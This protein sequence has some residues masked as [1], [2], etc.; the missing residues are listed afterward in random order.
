MT[1]EVPAGKE[2]RRCVRLG[3]SVRAHRSERLGESLRE[4]ETSEPSVLS[5][6]I[7][8]YVSHGSALF[9][10]LVL[11]NR[12]SAASAIARSMIASPVESKM[13]MS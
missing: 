5:V 1:P 6:S 9:D 4:A 10:G 8:S 11:P 2:A 13:V 7:C 12:S 3:V